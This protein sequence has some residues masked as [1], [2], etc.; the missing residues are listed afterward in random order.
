[1]AHTSS[2]A[3]MRPTTISVLSERKAQRIIEHLFHKKQRTITSEQE[4]IVLGKLIASCPPLVID[5]KRYFPFDKVKVFADN[6]KKAI[7]NDDPTIL[8]RPRG[9]KFEPIDVQEFIESHE[10]YGQKGHVWRSVRDE[11]W[12]IFH[13]RNPDG[14]P[15]TYVELVF[16]GAI[17][18]GKNYRAELCM[19]YTTYDLSTYYSPQ[20]EFNLAPG[21]AIVGIQQSKSLSLARKVVFDQFAARVRSSPYFKKKFMFDPNVKAELRFP[22][23]IFIYPLGGNDTAAFGMNVFFGVI[24]EMN[25]LLR[26]TESVILQYTGDDEFD[27]AERLYS[28]TIRRIKSRY[29]Q[30]GKVPG[31]LILVSSANYPGDFIDRKA[32]EAERDKTIFVSIKSQWEMRPREDMCEETFLVERGDELHGSR[33]IADMSM[34]RSGAIIETIPVDYKP[35]FERDIEGCL[36]DLGGRPTGASSPFIT[37]RE[38]IEKSQADHDVLFSGQSLFK[39]ANVGFPDIAAGDDPLNPGL[40]IN[41]LYVRDY[42]F[43]H[44]IYAIHIDVGITG[45][46]LGL[47]IGHIHGYKKLASTRIFD[48]HTNQFQELQDVFAPIYVIDGAIRCYALKGGEVDLNQLR[49][50]ALHLHSL[51]NLRWATADTYQS[52]QL[53]QAFKRLRIR[54]G[55]LSIDTSI[56]PYSELRDSLKDGRCLMPR[57]DV[58]SRELIGLQRVV[59]KN[60]LKV[61]HKKGE[62]KDVSDAVAGVVYMLQHKVARYSRVEESSSRLSEDQPIGMDRVIRTGDESRRLY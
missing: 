27:Q 31:K 34:A 22:N 13:G 6:I 40:V 18:I 5:G 53:L 35:D 11:M 44:Y 61:D 38:S 19:A 42:V 20:L 62:S 28:Q 16:G 59:E 57:N 26:T 33:I 36:R 58:L 47:A 41:D 56:A 48:K 55:P 12:E 49:T 9:R 52:T 43:P 8:S 54:S 45:D 24:D 60:S 50:F 25:F 17:G 51:V 1:M 14:S 15:R 30:H 32:K 46:S 39:V 4:E 23:N 21:S 10:Y 2:Q 37:S 29:M 7:E 3:A